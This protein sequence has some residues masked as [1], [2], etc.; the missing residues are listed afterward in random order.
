MNPR[1]A[2]PCWHCGQPAPSGA[3]IARTPEGKRDACCPGC[4]AAIE[5]IYGMGLDDYYRIRQDDAPAPDARRAELD[6]ALLKVLGTRTQTAKSEREARHAQ[7]KDWIN[8]GK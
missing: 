7:G 6:L 3:F 1:L 4:A 8:A 2:P 5:T